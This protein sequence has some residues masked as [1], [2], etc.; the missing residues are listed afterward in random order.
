MNNIERKSIEKSLDGR[1]PRDHS[2][3][4]PRFSREVTNEKNINWHMTN[5]PPGIRAFHWNLA[6]VNKEASV[7]CFVQRLVFFVASLTGFWNFVQTIVIYASQPPPNA[8]A[9]NPNP[10][11]LYSPE[12]ILGGALLMIII[13]IYGLFLHIFVF[14]MVGKLETFY[15]K[16]GFTIMTIFMLACLTFGILGSV[17]NFE[18]FA[19]ILRARNS[20]WLSNFWLIS[21]LIEASSWCALAIVELVLIIL[22]RHY[23]NGYATKVERERELIAQR[24]N[25][26]IVG[27]INDIKEK[28]STTSTGD[29]ASKAKNKIFGKTFTKV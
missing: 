26:G 8:T 19:N 13:F 29:V 5:Y 1:G 14:Y 11:Q 27:S 3:D 4:D 20:P 28:V 16:V 23:K 17:A 21:T 24:R 9:T 25:Q 10:G 6:E 22:M 7:L 12:C 2:K 18:G 15:W